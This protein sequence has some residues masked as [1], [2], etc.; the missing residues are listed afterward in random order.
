MTKLHDVFLK[1]NSDMNHGQAIYDLL[2]HDNLDIN[3]Q[4]EQ[5]NTVL[6][7]MAMYISSNYHNPYFHKPNPEGKFTNNTGYSGHF[8]MTNYQGPSFLEDLELFLRLGAN[9]TLKNKNGQTASDLFF[10]NSHFALQ[11]LDNYFQML[12]KYYPHASEIIAVI[13]YAALR[14]STYFQEKCFSQNLSFYPA[15]PW[16]EE[17]LPNLLDE[18]LLPL[19]CLE[20]LIK[21]I[22]STNLSEL[23]SKKTMNTIRE[24]LNNQ[25]NLQKSNPFLIGIMSKIATLYQTQKNTFRRAMLLNHPDYPLF[26]LIKQLSEVNHIESLLNQELVDYLNQILKDY[27]DT[28]IF[29]EQLKVSALD[30]IA[31]SEIKLIK[32]ICENLSDIL[33]GENQLKVTKS[34]NLKTDYSELRQF[35]AAKQHLFYSQQEVIKEL[36]QQFK[37]NESIKPSLL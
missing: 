9:P 32:P 35:M 11:H 29:W 4:D 26:D 24:R 31:L 8:Y 18:R 16:N 36:R 7:I 23:I 12:Q 6:H 37:E 13:N 2:K 33:E 34:W 22:D 20:K 21:W 1:K 10:K 28:R 27:E 14:S 15:N 19:D 5:G 3:A 30:P 17:K 25:L